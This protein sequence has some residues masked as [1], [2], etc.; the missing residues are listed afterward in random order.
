VE[1]AVAGAV[2]FATGFVV[3]L[4]EAGDLLEILKPLEFILADFGCRW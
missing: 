1:T 2:A 3:A 4:E